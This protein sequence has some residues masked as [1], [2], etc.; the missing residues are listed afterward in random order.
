MRL[1]HKDLIPILPRKQ[2]LSQWRECCAIAGEINKYGSPRSPLTRKIMD[3]PI[4]HFIIYSRC[5]MQE[6]SLRGYKVNSNTFDK[7]GLKPSPKSNGITYDELFHGWHNERY[8]KQC[9]YNLQEKYDCGGISE[10]EWRI[11]EN[12]SKCK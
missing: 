12:G 5:V 3:Y 9:Y 8:F 4:E 10:E 11:I 2:L 6:M 7:Y 1:W